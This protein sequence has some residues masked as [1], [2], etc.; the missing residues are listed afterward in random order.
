MNPAGKKV[1]T[2]REAAIVAMRLAGYDG[3]R[4]LWSILMRQSGVGVE[5]A[6]HAWTV[7]RRVRAAA[8]ESARVAT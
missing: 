2:K 5:T 3:N 7:G 1:P 6:Q 8:N 4:T